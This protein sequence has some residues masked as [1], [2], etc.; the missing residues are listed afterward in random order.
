MKAENRA[1]LMSA[2]VALLMGIA[3]VVFAVLTNS[4]AILLDGLFNLTYFAVA[5]VTIR[6]AR[7]A[8]RPDSP[9]FP[10]GHAYFESLVNA[11]KGLLI[12]G[13]S[14]VA[15]VDSLVALFTGGRAVEAGLAILYAGFATT[16]C[17]FTAWWLRRQQKLA[18]SP[19]VDADVENWLLNS[20]ISATVFLAFCMVPL[21]QW[22]GWNVIAAYIDPLLVACVVLIFLGVPIR[23]AS[24]AIME[25]LNRTPPA[26]IADPVR[27]AIEQAL[28]TQPVSRLYVRMVRPGR[29]LY[30]IIHVVL[31]A[32]FPVE[33]LATLDALR[34]RLD[35][36]VRQVHPQVVVDALFTAD[37]RWAAPKAGDGRA[38]IETV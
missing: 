14:A 3:G 4:G 2:A 22:L 26:G 27:L 13:I 28:V 16:V 10:F 18:G 9:E 36:A 37:E 32:D 25:L 31:P 23:L 1:L 29:T 38:V 21:A 33:R 17:S 6:V 12:F 5:V 20:I 7:L 19:L 15:L 11:G 34:L 8:T 24:R 35:Q 30:V